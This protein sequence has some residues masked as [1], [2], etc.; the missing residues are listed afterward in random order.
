VLHPIFP[1]PLVPA[2]ILPVHLPIAVSQIVKVRTYIAVATCPRKLSLTVLLI[3]K[4]MALIP[5]TALSPDTIPMPQTIF[6]VPF[7]VRD[8]LRPNILANSFRTTI[9]ITSC[10]TIS[11]LEH[12]LAVSMLQAT[13]YFTFV[14]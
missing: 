1:F 6:K 8:V 14:P 10:I 12:F 2:S 9:H 7:I 5:I 4:I 11:I 13:L 3:V